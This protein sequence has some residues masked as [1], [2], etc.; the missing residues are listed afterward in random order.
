M[1]QKAF[2]ERKVWS[3]GLGAKLAS[4]RSLGVS[5]IQVQRDRDYVKQVLD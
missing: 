3:L 1:A 5:V 2:M 4:I